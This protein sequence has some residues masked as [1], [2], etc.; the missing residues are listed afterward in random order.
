MRAAE[1][2]PAV[3]G[4]GGS[5][6]A[7]AGGLRTRRRHRC[8]LVRPA[9]TTPGGTGPRAPRGGLREGKGAAVV[10]KAQRHRRP[11]LCPARSGRPGAESC[12]GPEHRPPRPDRGDCA[13]RGVGWPQRPPPWPGK[14]GTSWEPGLERRDRGSPPHPPR[15]PPMGTRRWRLPQCAQVPPSAAP[16]RAAALPDARSPGVS[17][18]SAP[19][20]AAPG[21]RSAHGQPRSQR[22][23][24]PAAAQ[25]RVVK[26]PSKAGVLA[27]ARWNPKRAGAKGSGKAGQVCRLSREAAR[28]APGRAPAVPGLS[29][30][31]EPPAVASSQTHTEPALPGT[32]PRIAGPPEGPADTETLL[33]LSEQSKK[34]KKH[35]QLQEYDFK[36]FSR[37]LCLVT[38]RIGAPPPPGLPQGDPP[39]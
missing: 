7:W 23:R 24:S 5:G 35:Q 11:C 21:L 17:V 14:K 30:T 18:P 6:W 9:A 26:A 27:P 33:T 2:G 29:L 25:Q 4:R 36:V 28:L 3:A 13:V 15:L 12:D 31:G 39:D 20:I 34:V 1:T 38:S 37:Q 8:W 19:R 16:P 32:A 10:T 22:Q